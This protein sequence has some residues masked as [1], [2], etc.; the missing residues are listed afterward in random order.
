[1][2]WSRVRQ[3]T[4]LCSVY[5]VE[6]ICCC[7]WRDKQNHSVNEILSVLIENLVCKVSW[8]KLDC[9][10]QSLQVLTKTKRTFIMVKSYIGWLPYA[11]IILRT[12]IYVTT[13]SLTRQDSIIM[14]WKSTISH[15]D[16]LLHHKMLE[17][18]TS[19]S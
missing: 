12:I 4:Y 3:D 10:S 18:Y 11:A 17:L 6:T 7:S 9:F 1:M 8:F 14:L 13:C 16:C 19:I 5:P 2:Q 15:S